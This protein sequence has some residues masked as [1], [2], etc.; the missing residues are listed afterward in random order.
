MP[1]FKVTVNNEVYVV[2]APSKGT[3]RTWGKSQLRVSVEPAGPN[4]LRGVNLNDIPRVVPRLKNRKPDSPQPRT[5][6]ARTVKKR[7]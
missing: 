6:P 3:A 7:K 4:D 1:L 2:E 5:A